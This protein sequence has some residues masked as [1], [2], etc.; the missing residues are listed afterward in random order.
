M[1]TILRRDGYRFFFYSN[2]DGE[3][4]HIHVIREK[5][6]AKFWLSPAR[7][8]RNA[9]FPAHELGRILKMIDEN[10]EIIKNEWRKRVR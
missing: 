7:A 10:E 9:G 6:E 2:E 1:P 5:T 4:V 3:P 8:A